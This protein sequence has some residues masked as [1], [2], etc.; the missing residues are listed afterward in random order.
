MFSRLG[1]T[2]GKQQIHLNLVHFSPIESRAPRCNYRVGPLQDNLK[3]N[4]A[5]RSSS[6]ENTAD[7]PQQSEQSCNTAALFLV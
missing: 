3:P 5:I 1:K 4:I 6:V 2:A 7:F